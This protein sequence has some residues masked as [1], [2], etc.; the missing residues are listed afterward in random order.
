LTYLSLF[1]DSVEEAFI[2]GGL[3]A[4]IRTADEAYAA[5]FAKAL[6]KNKAFYQKVLGE[7]IH[8]LTY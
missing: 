3:A 8:Q 7:T 5:T 1:P 6:Q 2:C 4:I